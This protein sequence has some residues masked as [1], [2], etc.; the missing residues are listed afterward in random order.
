[1]QIAFAAIDDFKQEQRKNHGI[2]PFHEAQRLESFEANRRQ[3]QVKEEMLW[4][5]GAQHPYAVCEPN[6]QPD[7][8][9][10][11]VEGQGSLLVLR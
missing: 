5:C 3:P 7:D 11:I 1:M 8:D 10:G 6:D 9:K 4:P 2:G